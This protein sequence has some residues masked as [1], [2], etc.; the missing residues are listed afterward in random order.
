MIYQR[1]S[2]SSR[3]NL[4]ARRK[5]AYLSIARLPRGCLCNSDYGSDVPD[6][7]G[8]TLSPLQVSRA[9]AP[10]KVF[11][12]VLESAGLID[13]SFLPGEG[14]FNATKRRST[15]R[16]ATF[17]RSLVGPSVNSAILNKAIYYAFLAHWGQLSS[18]RNMHLP[19]YG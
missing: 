2:I 9:V 10:L 3:H 5:S 18:E 13:C 14:L 8:Y 19:D 1:L 17:I 12:V 7:S 4:P 16:V 11:S 15:Y 6:L